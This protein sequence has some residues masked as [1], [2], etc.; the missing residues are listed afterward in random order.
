MPKQQK[1]GGGSKKIGRSKKKCEI[2]RLENRR[3]KNK[4]LRQERRE[5]KLA[6]RRK[7]REMILVG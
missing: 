3:E 5:R 6:K 1:V 2:Y 4:K 7:K